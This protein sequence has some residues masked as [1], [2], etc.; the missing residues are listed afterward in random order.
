MIHEEIPR[1]LDGQRV[2][3]IVSLLGDISRSSAQALIAHLGVEVDG[4]I[5]TSGKI[6]LS[7]GQV[8]GIDLSK[9]PPP[10]FPLA[11][12]SIDISIEYA[13]NDIIVVNKHPGLVVHP[14]A[15]NP[16]GTLVNAVLAQF[17]EV[18]GVGQPMRPG[19]VHRL[20][21]GTSGLMV[22]ARSQNAYDSLVADLT[23]HTVT[24]EYLALA[25]GHFDA[26]SGVIDADI[27]RDPRDPMKM[28]VVRG[29]KW[30][31]THFVVE[32]SF[33]AP[34][35]LSL[36]RCSL[37]TGRTHQIRVHLGAVSHPVVGDATY[38]GARS[39]LIAS[40]PMLHAARLAFVHPATREQ[41]AFEVPIP[42]DMNDVLEQC[43]RIDTTE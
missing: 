34:A 24:R 42:Q 21:A 30:A 28:A 11:D 10:Q 17:P 8:I 41:V 38:G 12:A 32:E 13:D 2:D 23:D 4:K 33:D 36:V 29:G 1:A 40:R 43:S 27:G 7:E 25:W 16:D 3:R 37:E 5:E 20:D 9:L 19:I 31:R 26:E 14:G 39:T 18:A 6:R 22:I 35:P 15:G